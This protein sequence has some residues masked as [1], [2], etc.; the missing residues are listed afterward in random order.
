MAKKNAF[1]DA[2]KNETFTEVE[3]R[4]ENG[5]LARATTAN[6]C[7][8]LFYKIGAMRGQNVIPAFS[9]AYTENK[10][11]ALRIALWARDVRGGAGERKIF[12]DILRYLE[13]IRE[14][15]SLAVLL[16]RAPVVGRWDDL[17]SLNTLDG[18]HL[19]Y[20]IISMGLGATPYEV[21]EYK[22]LVGLC[23]K[24][25]PR[26]G[27]VAR[28]LRE[29]LGLSP[30]EYRKFLVGR[31]KVVESAMCAKDWNSINF[32]HVPSVAAARY[33]KAFYRNAKE[34]YQSYLNALKKGDPKVK[35]NAGAVYPYDVIKTAYRGDREA[36]EL[37]TAQWE[38]LPNYVGDAPVL[39][40]VDVSG[41]MTASVGGS[42][43]NLSAMDVAVSLGLYTADK[44]R[45][46][47][48]DCFLTFSGS[49]ELVKLRGNIIDKLDQLRRAHWEMNTNLHAAFDKILHT[50][51]KARVP[52]ED[53]PRTLL[54]LSDMQFDS[55][56]QYDDSAIKMIRR[57]YEEA[58]YQMPRVVF[59]NLRDAGNVPAK[60]NEQGV[61]LVSGFSPAVMKSVLAGDD[62]SPYAIML[63]TIMSPRYNVSPDVGEI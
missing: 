5:M 43:K 40:I 50:A 6:A 23:A 45:G 62:F 39:A 44:N 42:N 2:I 28:E 54:I 36:V 30:K 22:E 27:P 12:R 61:A 33:K 51:L 18:K 46:P 34:A 10:E 19:A 8:D 55:C 53:M 47:F 14:L 59:W 52:A 31:T 1:V 56:V 4:T 29:F 26:K 15:E 13:D 63:K 25:M 9:K 20:L 48:K 41:S 58:G 7:V 49:P 11:L 24:W 38:S 16:G 60:N 3:S 17:L 32:S 35:V 37:I 57:K 21:P